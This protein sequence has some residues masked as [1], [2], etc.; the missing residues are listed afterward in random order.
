MGGLSALF[1]ER[2]S[3]WSLVITSKRV[4]DLVPKQDKSVKGPV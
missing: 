2:V 4:F 3:A 1:A